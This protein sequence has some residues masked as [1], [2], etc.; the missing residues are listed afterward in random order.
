MIPPGLRPAAA[1][2]WPAVLIL[3]DRRC[4]SRLTGQPAGLHVLHV[5]NDGLGVLRWRSRIRLG[6]LLRQLACMHHHKA[7][8][9]ARAPAVAVL[10]LHWPDHTL[11]MPAARRLVLRPSRLLHYKRSHGLPLAPGVEFL[12]DSTGT[13]D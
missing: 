2:P 1:L 13:R 12:P 3:R 7:E 11:A 6:L 10:D 4:G 9:F 5:R 8:R